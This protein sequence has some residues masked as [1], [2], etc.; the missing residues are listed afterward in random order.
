MK[1]K[2]N[3][4]K[5]LDVHT[6]TSKEDIIEAAENKIFLADDARMERVYED[7]KNILLNPRKRT[8]AEIH[9]FCG[10]NDKQLTTWFGKMEKGNEVHSPFPNILCEFN[11]I[12]YSMENYSLR[13][14]LKQMY[15]M[16][17]LYKELTQDV[18]ADIINHER[19]QTEFPCIQDTS[20]IR[21]ALQEL[22]EDVHTSYVEAK[23]KLKTRD[24]YVNQVNIFARDALINRPVCG[25]LTDDVISTYRLDVYEDIKKREQRIYTLLEG[26]LE[27]SFLFEEL[28]GKKIHDVIT[29]TNKVAHILQPIELLNQNKGI[30]GR[31]KSETIG[32]Q[33]IDTAVD[34]YEYGDDIHGSLL[35]L[36]SVKE[37]FSYNRHLQNRCDK[38]IDMLKKELEDKKWETSPQEPDENIGEECV[39]SQEEPVV[40]AFDQASKKLSAI[41]EEIKK[42]VYLETGHEETNSVYCAD[43]FGEKY[44]KDVDDIARSEQFSEEEKA[45]LYA[46]IAA[47]YFQVAQAWY[48]TGNINEVLCNIDIAVEYAMDS[49]NDDIVYLV[50]TYQRKIKSEFEKA[51]VP[52]T[53]DTDKKREASFDNSNVVSVIITVVAAICIAIVFNSMIAFLLCI[54]GGIVLLLVGQDKD[55]QRK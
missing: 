25:M 21:R 37:Q 15:R 53:M 44:S 7:A 28:N 50:C 48:W 11:Y 32:K 38:N 6:T 27:N 13:K 35:L 12:K 17:G 31:S 2:E 24:A 26:I 9:W 29:Q 3:P 19:E 8:L 23:N 18:V 40:S 47:I 51:S 41:L 43:V 5:L 49:P 10:S 33:I 45:H 54:F 42:N 34:I 20:I 1:F 30:D 14:L 52:D 16:D 39:I 4:F 46:Q 22:R 55:D 36:E